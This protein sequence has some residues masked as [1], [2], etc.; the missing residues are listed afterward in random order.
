MNAIEIKRKLENVFNDQ[1][2]DVLAD[3][4]T[5]AYSDLVKTS[6]FNELKAIVKELAEAQK[7]LAEAQKRTEIE[8]Q[9]LAI[10]L[11]NLRV[12]VGGLSRSVSY[13]FENE[14]YRLLP[15][16]LKEKYGIV[17]KEKFIRAEINGKEI[18][19]FGKGIK[20]NKEVLIVGEVKLRLQKQK[21]EQ[22][23]EQKQ[24]GEQAVFDELEDK[25]SAVKN[26]YKQENIIK[27]LI[28]H[29]ATKEF[30]KEAEAKNIIV[31]QSFEL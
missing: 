21:Q 12:E 18:N 31:I 13:G 20:D 3:V 27:I 9:K 19:I 4:I 14:V 16:V 10:G 6:D 5:V 2:A 1:Q 28:A 15:N 26:E 11:N 8:V 22:K 7:E 24:G 25:V 23:Q 30:I 29:Y 17:M